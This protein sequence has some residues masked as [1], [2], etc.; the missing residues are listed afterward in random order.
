MS[1]ESISIVVVPRHFLPAPHESVIVNWG[2]GGGQEVT[3]DRLVV[4]GWDVPYHW[5]FRIRSHSCPLHVACLSRHGYIKGG[6]GGMGSM[7][8]GG[9]G[10]ISDMPI[11]VF[12]VRQVLVQYVLQKKRSRRTGWN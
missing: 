6:R 1:S 7:G 9:M 5:T 2:G 8:M 11:K 3:S 10:E 4:D 12:T